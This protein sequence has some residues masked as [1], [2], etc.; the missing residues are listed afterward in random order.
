M[1]LL[2]AVGGPLNQRILD[3]SA[4]ED[5]LNVRGPSQVVKPILGQLRELAADDS[6]HL[7]FMQ[8]V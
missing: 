7:Q 2:G 4:L 3:A 6:G 5:D 1:V 8:S